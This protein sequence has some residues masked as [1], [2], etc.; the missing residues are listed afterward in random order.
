MTIS[1]NCCFAGVFAKKCWRKYRTGGGRGGREGA[2]LFLCHSNIHISSL[3]RFRYHRAWVKLPFCAFNRRDRI[4]LQI[5]AIFVCSRECYLW[6]ATDLPIWW[7]EGRKANFHPSPSTF[8]YNTECPLL[9]RIV[10]L[11][12]PARLQRLSVDRSSMLKH[13]TATSQGSEKRKDFKVFFLLLISGKV[14]RRGANGAGDDLYEMVLR[15]QV[16]FPPYFRMSINGWPEV[17]PFFSLSI[18]YLPQ[19][20]ASTNKWSARPRQITLLFSTS[21]NNC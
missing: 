12:I 9:G 5:A 15:S 11:F 1:S 20:S 17:R 7:G 10:A 21:L 3:C 8:M 2:R 13:R 14:G 6:Q 4:S 19:P 16:S 18:D